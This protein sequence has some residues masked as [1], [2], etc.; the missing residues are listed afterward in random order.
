MVDLS[1]F[2]SNKK[3]LS[4][5]IV[6]I[7][8]QVCGWKEKIVSKKKK[9][10]ILTDKEILSNMLPMLLIWYKKGEVM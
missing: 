10:F 5:V 2:I 1:K 3:I 7:K 8:N 4:G 9:I 6:L